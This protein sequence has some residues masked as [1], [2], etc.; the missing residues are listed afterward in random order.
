[1]ARS[2]IAPRSRKI[3]AA[4]RTRFTELVV[5]RL[6]PP[7][8]GSYVVWNSTTSTLRH[9]GQQDRTQDLAPWP[10]APRPLARDVAQG[11][12]RPDGRRR[13]GTA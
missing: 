1:M 2:K 10:A 5:E 7:T 8:S 6:K 11:G 13:A 4:N 3:A 9:P 12:A